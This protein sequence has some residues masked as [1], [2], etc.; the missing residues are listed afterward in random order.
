PRDYPARLGQVGDVVQDRE[1]HDA[2]RTA[3][4][5]SRGRLLEYRVR[6]LDVGVQVG[7]D[8]FRAAGQQRAGV[9]KDKRVVVDVDDPAFRRGGLG[10][11]MGVVRRGQPGADVEELPDSLRGGQVAYG[12]PEKRPVGLRGQLDAG[13]RRNRLLAGDPV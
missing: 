12:P 4:V 13:E 11:L 1:Q 6:V 2:D 3:E 9:G 8:T 10:H 7:R 5:E